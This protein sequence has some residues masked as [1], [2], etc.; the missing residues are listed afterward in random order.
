M[1]LVVTRN[2]NDTKILT[3]DGRDI[4][5]DLCAKKISVVMMAN[6]VTRIYIE[7]FG[8]EV[9]GIVFNDFV[10]HQV[11]HVP[12]DSKT[13]LRQVFSNVKSWFI[14]G[15][16]HG[17]KDTIK[18]HKLKFD[19]WIGKHRAILAIR[20]LTIKIKRMIDD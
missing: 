13:C 8:W 16:I 3:D 6:D 20:R 5:T 7:S 17:T 9:E 2:A 18:E 1:K 12:L 10:E 14:Y 4:T 11:T 19:V 15:V